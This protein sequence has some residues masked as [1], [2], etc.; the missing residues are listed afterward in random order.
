[1]TVV[2]CLFEVSPLIKIPARKQH[3]VA[4]TVFILLP[5]SRADD[6]AVDLGGLALI[7]AILVIN[8][9]PHYP[10]ILPLPARYSTEAQD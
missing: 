2:L 9:H 4:S 7:R 1:M 6:R 8:C 3:A 5:R 10:I